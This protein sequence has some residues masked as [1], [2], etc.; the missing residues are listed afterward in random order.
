M[1]WRISQN[2]RFFRVGLLVLSLISIVF[3]AFA[4][5]GN[6]AEDEENQEPASEAAEAAPAEIAN[7]DESSSLDASIAAPE[8]DGEEK[9]ESTP[10]PPDPTNPNPPDLMKKKLARKEP[11]RTHYDIYLGD[12]KVHGDPLPDETP[13]HITVHFSNGKKKEFLAAKSWDFD[14]DGQADMI[15]ILDESSKEIAYIFDFDDDG[16]PDFVRLK[17]KD[18]KK[19]AAQWEERVALPGEEMKF[20]EA[21]GMPKVA[22]KPGSKDKV[23]EF[24]SYS[25]TIVSF[26]FISTKIAA[27]QKD[28]GATAE[29]FSTSHLGMGLGRAFHMTPK[30]ALMPWL[31]IRQLNLAKPEDGEQGLT[32]RTP[33]M[34]AVGL[35]LQYNF[36]ERLRFDTALKIDQQPYLRGDSLTGAIVKKVLLPKLDLGLVWDAMIFG[37][38]TV[39][40]D[41]RVGL[42]MPRKSGD[43]ETTL[44]KDYRGEL[45]VKRPIWDYIVKFG[46]YGDMIEQNTKDVEQKETDFGMRIELTLPMGVKK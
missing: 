32:G 1:A 29:S 28:N 17:K 45:F 25:A 19:G 10:M 24:E 36:T 20:P 26:D 39:G 37:Y 43:I 16:R 22:H 38:T 6:S 33:L 7:P 34:F 40:V 5:T 12:S 31:Q 11:V 4:T 30:W 9:A 8:G 2:F 46:F 42:F 3:T 44:N 15:Q 23:D 14:H 13:V 41:G 21:A 18:S 27:T 35:A